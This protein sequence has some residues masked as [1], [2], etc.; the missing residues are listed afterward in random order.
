MLSLF[1]A[2]RDSEVGSSKYEGTLSDAYWSWN[3]TTYLQ[4]R[5]HISSR[6]PIHSQEIY[7]QIGKISD[8][9]EMHGK[10]WVLRKEINHSAKW[11]L[12]KG[13]P[14]HSSQTRPKQPFLYDCQTKRVL[15]GVD[16]MK[17]I[18]IY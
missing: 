18:M 14:K 5:G 12:S 15:A 2:A 13:S 4:T 16:V 9:L 3:A 8:Q 11:I 6:L 10:K 17:S 1:L 7:A